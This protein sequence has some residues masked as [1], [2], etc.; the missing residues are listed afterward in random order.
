MTLNTVSKFYIIFHLIPF[1]LK[2]K[3][4][5]RER[6]LFKGSMRALTNFLGSLCFMIHLVCG[7]KAGLCLYSNADLKIGG[8]LYFKP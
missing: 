4:L 7:L 8:I 2:V 3:K 5:I 1:A 6:R